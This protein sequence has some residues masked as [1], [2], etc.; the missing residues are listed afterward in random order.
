MTTSYKVA[1]G[2]VISA[3]CLALMFMTGMFPLLSMAIPI[4]AGAMMIIV[5]KEVSPGW[6]YAAYCAVSLLSLFLTP[7]KEASTLFIFFFGYYPILLP[8]LNGIKAK[9]LRIIVKLGVFNFA[10]ILWYKLI[11]FMLGIYDYFGDF[12][13]LGRFAMPAVLIFVNLIFAMYDY[14]VKLIEEVYVNWFRPTYFGKKKPKK[15]AET[16]KK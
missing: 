14:T 12:A 9:L 4:Y 1:V 3:L 7:D 15:K 8:K 5:A 13:F 16:E 10:V 11:T 2:G 6:A